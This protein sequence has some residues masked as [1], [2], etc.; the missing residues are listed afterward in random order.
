MTRPFPRRA[1]L[2]AAVAVVLIG[3]PSASAAL[4]FSFNRATASPGTRVTASQPGWPGAAHGVA[5]YLISS[6]PAGI[7]PDP[8][9]GYILRRPPAGAIRLGQPRLIRDHRLT[10]SF[11]V[12]EVD[13][14]DYTI[15]FW[16]RT[17]ATGGDFFASA[18]WGSH[19][20]GK[21]GMVIHIAKP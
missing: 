4:S 2:I 9:G 5:A 11:R 15:A 12:P 18:P 7:R 19:A 1:A 8:A 21:P 20:T 17:C 16:C 13:A 6:E 10:I 3:V 14:G